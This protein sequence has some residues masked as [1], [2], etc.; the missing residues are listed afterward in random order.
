MSVHFILFFTIISIAGGKS[1]KREKS[2][3]STLVVN[4]VS[5]SFSDAAS[6]PQLIKWAKE[7][8]KTQGSVTHA[9]AVSRERFVVE[10]VN[11]GLWSTATYHEYQR[12]AASSGNVDSA[13]LLLQSV[14]PVDFFPSFFYAVN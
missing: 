8:T 13:R 4:G 1:L 3:S 6:A 10:Q 9:Q 12:L 7:L 11:S 2:I 14:F 5:L